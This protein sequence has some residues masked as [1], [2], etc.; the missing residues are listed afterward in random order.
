[1]TVV[2]LAALRIRANGTCVDD[3][4][5]SDGTAAGVPTSSVTASVDRSKTTM[6]LRGVAPIGFAPSTSRVIC[7]LF[8]SGDTPD[9]VASCTTARPA[10]TSTDAAPPPLWVTARPSTTPVAAL[11]VDT[12]ANRYAIA[13][14]NCDSDSPSFHACQVDI[15]HHAPS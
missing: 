13:C 15:Y 5:G 9:R 8:T 7:A 10:D 12:F 4:D 14:R 3:T 11:P 6:S 1:M 2:A